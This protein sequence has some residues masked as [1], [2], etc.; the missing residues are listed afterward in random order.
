MHLSLRTFLLLLLCTFMTATTLQAAGKKKKAKTATT[1]DS[2][3]HW[4]TINEA[5]EAMKKQPKRVFVDIYTH[6]CGWCKVMDKKTFSNKELAQYMNEHFY[7]VK[8]N[9]EQQ[10]TIRFMGRAFGFVPAQRSNQ[11]AVELLQGRMSYPTTVI[12]EEGFKNPIPIP[13]YQNVPTMEK[14]LKYIAS[15]T[16][17]TVQFPDYEKTF[18]P[19]WKETSTE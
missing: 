15:G 2:T 7:A 4:L 6:W 19:V 12:L 18:V 10:D 1:A 3:I 5:E 16:Y 11:L 8:L 13:G 17:K 9:A 14:I